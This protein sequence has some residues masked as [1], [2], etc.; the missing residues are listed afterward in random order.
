[1]KFVVRVQQRSFEVHVGGRAPGYELTIDGRV[2][3]VDAAD[4]GD[5]SLLTMLLDQ[6]SFLAHTRVADAQRGLYDV[7]IAGKYRRLEV[8]DALASA[9]Q[10]RAEAAA[11]GRCVVTAPMP[12]LV[13]AVHVRPGDAVQIGTPLVV[14][15]AMKMQNELASEV[16][17]SVHEVHVAADQAVE[18]GAPLVVIEAG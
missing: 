16:A 11:G 2:F 7:S 1:M 3:R 4:L 5:T 17:G 10:E 13:V 6:E 14:I 18:S 12:G 8:L 9:T 15:E